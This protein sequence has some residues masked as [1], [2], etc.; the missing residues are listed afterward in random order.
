MWH[1]ENLTSELVIFIDTDFSYNNQWSD[2][3]ELILGRLEGPPPMA[4]E[5]VQQLLGLWVVVGHICEQR[6]VTQG[7]LPL[8]AGHPQQDMTSTGSACM[9]QIKTIQMQ[10]PGITSWRILSNR[11]CFHALFIH[12]YILVKMASF[13]LI[14]AFFW[15]FVRNQYC[16]SPALCYICIFVS[17]L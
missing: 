8:L 2:G 12:I 14:D 1:P 16:T 17:Y 7:L 9:V 11:I 10:A 13:E 4:P 3:T 15:A 5:A 6:D